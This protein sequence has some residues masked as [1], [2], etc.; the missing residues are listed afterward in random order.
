MPNLQIP[1]SKTTVY[2][3]ASN[4]QHEKYNGI[5]WS[6]VKFALK[7]SK[8]AYFKMGGSVATSSAFHVFFALYLNK[9]NAT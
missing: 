6:G 9:F 4:R 8:F 1:T 7:K 3:S 2:D 5:I